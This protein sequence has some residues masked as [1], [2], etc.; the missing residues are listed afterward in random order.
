MPGGR[1]SSDRRLRSPA[2]RHPDRTGRETRLLCRRRWLVRASSWFRDCDT[3]RQFADLNGLDYFE[4]RNIDNGHIIRYA[5]RDQKEFFIW[6]KRHMPDA[7]ADQ[8]VFGDLMAYG[9]D[10][11]D[12][13]GRPK[14]YEGGLCVGSDTD[15]NRL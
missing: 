11:R 1:H 5:I 9:I 14:C 13:V 8:Q 7:L 15:P 3:P 12:A 10:H 6:G 4:R 2:R